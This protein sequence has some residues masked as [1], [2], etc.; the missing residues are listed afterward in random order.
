MSFDHCDHSGCNKLKL[1]RSPVARGTLHPPERMA[2]R[3]SVEDERAMLK[4]SLSVDL[5]FMVVNYAR[6]WIAN[7]QEICL[8]CACCLT[9]KVFPEKFLLILTYALGH[10]R[11][12]HEVMSHWQPIEEKFEAE[13]NGMTFSNR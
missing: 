8:M 13:F 10:P 12:I 2:I 5:I 7:I 9:Q 4:F 1:R 6:Q 3:E 11:P